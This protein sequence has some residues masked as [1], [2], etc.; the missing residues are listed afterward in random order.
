MNNCDKK[1]QITT[2]ILNICQ[3]MISP[4]PLQASPSPPAQLVAFL[5]GSYSSR[6]WEQTFG[7]GFHIFAA[8]IILSCSSFLK[9]LV[10]T[11]FLMPLPTDVLHNSFH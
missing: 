1:P 8:V 9:K 5:W 11:T 6:F 3:D 10:S 2:H 4:F 7:R